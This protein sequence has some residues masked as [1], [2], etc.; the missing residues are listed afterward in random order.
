MLGASADNGASC[1]PPPFTPLVPVCL[2]N[3]A[4]TGKY[5]TSCHELD[6]MCFSTGEVLVLCVGLS[7]FLLRQVLIILYACALSR[8]AGAERGDSPDQ[9]WERRYRHLFLCPCYRLTL[10]ITLARSA[11]LARASMS[12]ERSGGACI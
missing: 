6:C 10:A 9:G 7:M 2:C 12:I 8:G 4:G 3:K 11:L 1:Q 5:M